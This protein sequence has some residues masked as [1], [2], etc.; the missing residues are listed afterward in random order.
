[1]A[2][3]SAKVVLVTGATRGLGLGLAE[4]LAEAGATVYVTGRTRQ[5]VAAAAGRVDELGGKGRPWCLDHGSENDVRC[6]FECLQT[7]HGGL[8]VL[9]N[10]VS[11]GADLAAACAS[12]LMAGRANALIVDVV[13]AAPPGEPAEAAESAAGPVR[14]A[15]A[16]DATRPR[17]SGRCV[18]ALAMDPDIRDKD[19]GYHRVVALE[20]EYRF[21]DPAVPVPGTH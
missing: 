2:D 7:E 10:H 19:G 8:D 4:G 16:M 20:R 1:M 21:S 9:V 5:G 17:Y 15:L 14:L 18:A 11:T 6:L 3:L 12:A 13:A